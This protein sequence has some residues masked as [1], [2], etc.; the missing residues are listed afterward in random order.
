MKS[1][2]LE[3]KDY[4]KDSFHD[5][6]CRFVRAMG[7]RV[8]YDKWKEGGLKHYI[9]NR[10]MGVSCFNAADFLRSRGDIKAYINEC[11]KK[12]NTKQMV[13]NCLENCIR[14]MK[15]KDMQ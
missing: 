13:I 12:Q 1:V 7:E 2:F 4:T 11:L 10:E 14:A 3:I 15:R 6:F 8:A 5:W 9:Y